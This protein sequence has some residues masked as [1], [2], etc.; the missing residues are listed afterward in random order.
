MIDKKSPTS[1]MT[2]K[3]TQAYVSL[4]CEGGQLLLAY[5]LAAA[6]RLNAC[7]AI[8]VTDKAGQILCSVR[9]DEAPGVSID[10]AARKA[11]TSAQLGVAT[12]AIQQ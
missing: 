6:G 10:L 8:A 11:W 4:T 7:V 12:A 3:L 5:A 2:R 9:M 1:D